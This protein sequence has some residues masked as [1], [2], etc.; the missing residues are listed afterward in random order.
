MHRATLPTGEEVVVKVQRPNA[1]RQIESDLV[2]MR[3]AARFVRDR[4]RAL[5]FIDAEALVDE[6]GRAIREELDYLHE[7]RNAEA[8]RRNFG[9]DERVADPG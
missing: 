2:L 3:S 7:A 8:F 5:D 6:F 9:D 4:V 1:P